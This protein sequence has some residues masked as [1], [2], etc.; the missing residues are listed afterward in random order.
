MLLVERTVLSVLVLKCFYSFFD[1]R[2]FTNTLFHLCNMNQFNGKNGCAWCTQE[3]EVVRKGN[4]H[5]RVYSTTGSKHALR[6]HDSFLKDAETAEQAAQAAC[7]VK[8]PSILFRL[9]FFAFPCGFVVDHMHAVCSGFVRHTAFMWLSHNSAFPYSLGGKIDEIDS[10][11]QLL[12]P[13]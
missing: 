3:G 6:T 7:V 5:A 12:Q 4:G 11:L 8:E 1:S 9:S 13:L 2:I 10:R